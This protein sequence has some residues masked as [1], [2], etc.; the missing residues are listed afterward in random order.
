MALQEQIERL[1]KYFADLKLDELGAVFARHARA[2]T[3]RTLTALHELELGALVEDLAVAIAFYTR[4]PLRR[5]TP[6][7]GAA[8]ARAAWCAPLIGALVGVVA[9]L[10]YWA[11]YR[12][13]LPQFVCATLAIAAALA[14]TGCLHEDGLADT[15]DGF[16][17]ATREESLAIMRDGRIGVFG[18][19]ALIVALTLRV[20]ALADLPNPALAAWALIATHAAARA[21]LPPFMRL[22]APAR[23]DGLS[24]AAGAPALEQ[25]WTSALIGLAILWIALGTKN[26][27]IA[28]LL[29]VVGGAVV[30]WL[31]N[32]KLGGQTGDVLGALEQ[33]GE[34]LVLLVAAA[35]F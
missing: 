5:T 11:A 3:E 7:D 29:L 31:A 12:L 26:M 17:G 4:L 23:P 10:A 32:R 24:A 25:A 30:A 15:A 21:S 14:L 35:R 6:V 16:G 9:G 2:L 18:A 33:V 34:C 27:L 20:G 19:C 8:I 13:N 28:L 1:R 22:V